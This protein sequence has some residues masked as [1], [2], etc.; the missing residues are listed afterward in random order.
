MSDR[1]AT[2]V[3]FALIGSAC[4][5]IAAMPHLPAYSA[6]VTWATKLLS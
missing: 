1:F 6:A 5:V 3:I 2:L 4:F